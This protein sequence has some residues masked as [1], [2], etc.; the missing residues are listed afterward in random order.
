VF[1]SFAICDPSGTFV[2][3]GE[4]TNQKLWTVPI[5]GAGISPLASLAFNYDATFSPNGELFVSA[6][7]GGFGFGNDI[8]K[9]AIPGGALTPIA[10]VNGPSGPLAFDASGNLYYATQGPGFPA[11]AGSTDVI[12]WSAAQVLAG[13]LTNANAANV[14]TGLD[15]GASLAID[16]STQ[17]IYIAET[18]FLLGTNRVRR[19]GPT[20]ANSP[21]VADAGALSI[22]GM[23][24]IAGPSAA[25]FDAYQPDTGV[26]L[27]YGATDFFSASERSIAAPARPQLTLSGP[28]LSGPGPVTM[29]LTGGV[30]N[31][32]AYLLYCSQ[33]ALSPTELP[34][35]FPGFLFHTKFLLS[36]TRRL[37][38]YLPS[39]AS[40]TCVFQIQNPGGLQGL[41]AYQFLV[42]GSTGI[43]VGSSN[44]A[45]F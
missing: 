20:R 32:S 31:G 44:S 43:F 9:V 3:V 25:T 7:T 34:Q 4:S 16:P 2:V 36:Q 1:A 13:G 28:G 10:H 30:P 15:G 5:S 12:T 24:F 40:G 42:G 45:Q 14:C 22:F 18:S 26:R 39:D 29:T 21:I 11:P 8:F 41:K 19:V 23:Q 38:F 27:V 37:P 35:P 33:A 6:A 17:K